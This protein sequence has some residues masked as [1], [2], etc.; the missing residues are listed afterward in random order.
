MVSHLAFRLRIYLSILICIFLVGMAGLIIIE[1]FPP[2][3]AF[4]LIVSTIST[5]GYGDLHPVTPAG[6]I[7]VVL[8]ILTGAVVLWE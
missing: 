6:K 1:H 2:L 7:L 5:V 4:Y 8:I 3:D